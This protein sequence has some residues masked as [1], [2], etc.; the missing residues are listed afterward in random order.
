M[1]DHAVTT[2]NSGAATEEATMPD[3]AA[4]GRRTSLGIVAA[5]LALGSLFGP[6]AASGIWEPHELRVADLARRIAV[7]L[8]GAKRLWIDGG[9]NTVP[10]ASDLGK[11]ELPFTT[12]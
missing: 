7:T 6:I 4:S 1:T 2:E 8:L 12:I 3:P 10:T 9:V 11:G 5:L